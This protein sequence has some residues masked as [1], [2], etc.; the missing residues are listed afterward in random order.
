M[1]KNKQVLKQQ[2]RGLDPGDLVCVEWSDASVGKSMHA[3]AGGIEVPVSSWG[4]FISLLGKNPEHIVLA[5]NNFRYADGLYD[6]D[7]TAIPAPWACKVSVL[8]KGHVDSE[9]ARHLLESFLLHGRARI[10][11]SCG[12]QQRLRVHEA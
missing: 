6:I 8:I 5:Q 9:T 3:G 11:K 7:Y 10:S 1:M 12:H 4:I 2:L